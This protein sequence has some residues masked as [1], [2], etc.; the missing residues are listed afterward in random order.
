MEAE[1]DQAV[2][3]CEAQ[4]VGKRLVFRDSAGQQVENERGAQGA[5][6]VADVMR[7]ELAGVDCH[8]GFEEA[9]APA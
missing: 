3:P 5:C 7:P 9:I 6:E 2:F 8:A 4:E 1:D